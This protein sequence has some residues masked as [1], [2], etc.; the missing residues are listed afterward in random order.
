MT[1]PKSFSN[2]TLFDLLDNIVGQLNDH[3]KE[4]AVLAAY[5]IAGADGNVEDSEMALIQ[6]IGTSLSLSA[7]HLTG[8]LTTAQQQNPAAIQ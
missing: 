2:S 3:A 8:I 1:I 6:Q 7:A 5:L 4:T